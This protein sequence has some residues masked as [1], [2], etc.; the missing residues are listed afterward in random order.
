ED[1]LKFQP[2]IADEFDRRRFVGT[3]GSDDHAADRHTLRTSLDQLLPELV[4][5]TFG[6]RA[7]FACRRTVE[8]SPILRHD[9][10]EQIKPRKHF[11]EII[12]FTARNQNEFA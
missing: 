8:Q 12:E 11:D 10:I 4:R 7:F 9:S 5:W 3:P 1:D 2:E 6:K